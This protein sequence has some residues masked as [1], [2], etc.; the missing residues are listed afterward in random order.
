MNLNVGIGRLTYCAPH[1]NVGG[2]VKALTYM[3]MDDLMVMPMSATSVISLLNQYNVKDVEVLE[4][5][6]LKVGKD[7]VQIQS[8]FLAH[9]SGF[10]KFGVQV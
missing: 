8:F 2:Y 5:K 10:V 1:S 6:V 9:F 3:V 7:E 4:E